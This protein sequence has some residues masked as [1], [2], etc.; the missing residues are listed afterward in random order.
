MVSG[1][2]TEASPRDPA[3]D[4]AL[5]GVLARLSEGAALP[6]EHAGVGALTR[7]LTVDTPPLTLIEAQVRELSRAHPTRTQRDVLARQPRAGQR[8]LDVR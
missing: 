6:R 7:M 8:Q 2:G 1:R 3:L 5:R 4:Q